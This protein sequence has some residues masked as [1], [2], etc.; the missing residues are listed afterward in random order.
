MRAIGSAPVPGG[1][2]DGLLGQA[3]RFTNVARATLGGRTGLPSRRRTRVAALFAR[4]ALELVVN[5]RLAHAVRRNIAAR[6]GQGALQFDKPDSWRAAYALAGN[7]EHDRC[8]DFAPHW[9]YP[10]PAKIERH[11]A[12][13]PLSAD[14]PRY[15]RLKEDVALYRLTFGQPRQE[16]MLELL[17]GRGTDPRTEVS[18]G[19]T[20]AHPRQLARMLVV[21]IEA[22]VRTL[23]RYAS[24]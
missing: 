3:Q 20:F 5:A 10:G 19:S 18:A 24:L 4:T 22:C 6:H 8:G 23:R 13:F 14:R 21:C 12:P 16:D 15:Q 2:A 1:A 9:V 17:R 7:D 11:L